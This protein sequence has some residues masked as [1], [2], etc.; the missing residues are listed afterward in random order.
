MRIKS[1]LGLSIA[2]AKTEFKLKNEGSYFG[3]LWYLLNPILMFLLLFFVFSNRLGSNIEYYP[4]YLLLGIITFNFFQYATTEATKQIIINDRL[5]KSIHFPYSALI[6]G[7]VLKTLFSHIFEILV[8]IVFLLLFGISLQGVILYPAILFF[9][10]CFILG[11]SLLLSSVSVY[12]ID[13]EPIWIF[14]SRLLWFAT[15]IFYAIDDHT[16]LYYINLF[17]PLYYFITVSRDILIY[18]RIP[19]PQIL[20][21]IVIFSIIPLVL[22]FIVFNRLKHKFPEML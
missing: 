8:L 3:M 15:P 11:V 6:G 18:H 9:Y 20:I 10:F 5:I 2:I 7:V 1:F 12:F 4:V 21:S 16:K 19:H 13:L 17:N 14:I 22:G